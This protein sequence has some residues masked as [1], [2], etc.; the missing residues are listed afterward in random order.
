[1]ESSPKSTVR[2]RPMDGRPGD[3][4]GGDASGPPDTGWVEELQGF[5]AVTLPSGE[6]IVARRIANYAGGWR[7]CST[8]R[9]AFFSEGPCPI[10]GRA[11][12][13][14]AR[15]RRRRSRSVQRIEVDET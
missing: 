3:D 13:R 9:L 12:R 5:V 11:L 2:R 14:G 4:P 7:W 8:C 6:K 1:M 15:I 10:C